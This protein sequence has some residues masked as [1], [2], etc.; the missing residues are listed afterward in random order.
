MEGEGKP[1]NGI[2]EAGAGLLLGPAQVHLPR[3][4]CDLGGLRTEGSPKTTN[5]G[6]PQRSQPLAFLCQGRGLQTQR[7]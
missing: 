6:W 1:L 7:G 3:P 2:Q 5:L 4:A